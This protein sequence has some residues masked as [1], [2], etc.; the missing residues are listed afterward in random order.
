MGCID[1]M[2]EDGVVR[3]LAPADGVSKK[4]TR[5]L[6]LA[7]EDTVFVTYHANANNCQDVTELEKRLFKVYKNP[8]LNNKKM[9]VIK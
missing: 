6:G 3:Y 9:E 2:T 7:L 1:V 5:K 8:L 4:G